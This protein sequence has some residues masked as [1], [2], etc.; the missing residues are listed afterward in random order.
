MTHTGRLLARAVA[1]IE[2]RLAENLPLAE[3]AREAGMS[4]WHFH[5]T[6]TA[7]TGDTPASYVRRRR[8]AESC[9]RLRE[10]DAPLVE[11]ALDGGFASQASF[12]RAF[13][14]HTGVSPGA[15]RRDGLRT[16]AYD[17]APIDLETRITENGR[18]TNME[19]KIVDRPAFRIVGMAG[20]YDLETNVQIPS[21]WA[22][23]EP[24]IPSIE[25]RSSE[26]TFGVCC[27]DDRVGAPQ[28]RRLVDTP[29]KD[30]GSD[31][32]TFVYVAAAAVTPDAP[33]PDG[34][35]SIEIPENRY[36]VF[37]HS[38]HL[39]GLREFARRIWGEWLPA[40]SLRT[41]DAPD[42]ELYD[43]RMDPATGEG[44]VDVYVPIARDA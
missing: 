9:R 13:T 33:L 21:L 42:F 35:I 1:C 17:F 2:E 40:S 4:P 19:P 7:V 39:S 5:R 3:V 12:T 36:A 34:M 18:R 31:G 14:R 30:L 27:S 23:F 44:E 22:R 8:V 41:V 43:E 10:T 38:G 26:E 28:M 29:T 20:R 16:P 25:G 24:L 37:T 6:F 32:A 15:Y 11:I